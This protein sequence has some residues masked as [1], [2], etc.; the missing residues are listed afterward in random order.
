MKIARFVRVSARRFGLD[1]QRSS[2]TIS[3]VRQRLLSAMLTDL[4]VDVGAAEG[5]YVRQLRAESKY[6]GAVL[7]IE[8]RGDAF[9]ALQQRAATDSRWDVERGALGT[10]VG[11]AEI[12]I[13]A[14]PHSSS[15]L[16]PH[17]SSSVAELVVQRVES[18]LVRRLDDVLSDM[19]FRSA[20]LKIDTQGGE[21][22]VLQS[23]SGCLDAVASIEV[24]LS[25]TRLYE[26]QALIEDVVGHLRHVGF[27]PIHFERGFVDP[28]SLDVVQVDGL[29]RRVGRSG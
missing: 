18:V 29:F 8:P 1:V 3:S 7:S 12:N 6:F 17:L 16:R 23:G 20:H 5:Q 22:D 19:R 4:V 15:L 9:R 24:E 21:L 13:T 10:I 25:F 11:P 28:G 26:G 27:A 2:H 14:Q